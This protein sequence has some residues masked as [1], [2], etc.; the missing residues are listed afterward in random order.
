[1]TTGSTP[2]QSPAPVLKNA[3]ACVRRGAP[4]PARAR[5]GRATTGRRQSSAS[6][7]GRVAHR[8]HEVGAQQPVRAERLERVGGVADDADGRVCLDRRHARARALEDQR[9]DAVERRRQPR[10]LH[11]VRLER[12]A[13]QRAAHA[14]AAHRRHARE[15]GVLQVVGGGVAA[16]RRQRL[17]VLERDVGRRDHGLRRPAPPHRDDRGAARR[18]S[19]ST[20]ARWHD[21]AV[22]PVRLPVPITAMHRPA[23]VELLVARRVER[24]ASAS[25]YA[26]PRWSASD[27]SRSFASA[28]RT[29]SS[30]RS[31]TAVAPG[32][33]RRS[34]S[35][36]GS[37][38]SNSIP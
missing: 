2:A 32:A 30:A 19:R 8:Q 22:L 16:R 17:E 11:H 38:G 36:R 18:A 24:L 31:T 3:D 37:S 9:V 28:A 12:H 10:A 1:M 27:A 23:E 4:R 33:S 25:S 20:P 13:G 26:S 5:A 29:G 34:A 35:S 7:V 21:T 6:S 15:H 14:A